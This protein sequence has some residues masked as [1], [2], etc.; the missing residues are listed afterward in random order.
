MKLIRAFFSLIFFAGVSLAQAEGFALSSSDI[1]GQLSNK[2]VYSGFGCSGENISPALNW[3]N[4]PKGTKSFAVTVYDS[5]A[6]TGSGWWHWLIVDIP[7]SA[8]DLKSNAGNIIAGLAPKGSVQTVTDFGPAGFGGACPPPDAKPHQYIFTVYALK[9]ESLGL[10]TDAMPALVG[11]MLA[12][13]VLAK[14]SIVAYYA[15]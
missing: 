3:T 8:K 9:V 11:Y 15:R 1:A 12:S 6:P 14:A 2:E 13:N 10:K 4:A 5:D 7:G